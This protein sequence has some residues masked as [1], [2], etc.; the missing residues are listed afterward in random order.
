MFYNSI[1]ILCWLQV[2]F[3]TD[4]SVVGT[5]F[6][7]DFDYLNEQHDPCV[8]THALGVSADTEVSKP[9]SYLSMSYD[10][11]PQVHVINKSF[12]K[13]CLSQLYYFEADNHFHFVNFSHS[14]VIRLL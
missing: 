6:S 4:G 3:T 9:V 7:A 11:D 14:V 8:K 13:T 1:N 10:S 2:V 5:G 12:C